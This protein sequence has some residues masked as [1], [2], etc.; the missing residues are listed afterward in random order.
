LRLDSEKQALLAR[1]LN[2]LALAEVGGEGDHL[3][4]IRGL[5]PL[6]DDGGVEAAGIG[7]H[8][9]FHR[10]LFGAALGHGR[11]RPATPTLLTSSPAMPAPPTAS[12]PGSTRASSSFAETMD[13][14]VIRA[15][16]RSPPSGRLRPSSRPVDGRPRP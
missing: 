12:C 8:H 9:L 10:A 5:Q 14:Q 2:L 3:A 16:T 11:L 4:A 1:G 15:S 7:Q 6:Q 13:G